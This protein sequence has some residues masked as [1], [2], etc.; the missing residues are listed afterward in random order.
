MTSA[1][2]WPVGPAPLHPIVCRTIRQGLLE[3]EAFLVGIVAK[4]LV[5]EAPVLRDR[6]LR[7]NPAVQRCKRTLPG[8]GI[9][10]HSRV[11]DGNPGIA[12]NTG[13]EVRVGRNDCPLR[14]QFGGLSA[15]P[16]PV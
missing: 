3:A 1:P 11:A 10:R 6:L 4:G 7:T 12:D 9:Q 5:P 15:S 14:Q 2:E 16:A 8:K 13:I